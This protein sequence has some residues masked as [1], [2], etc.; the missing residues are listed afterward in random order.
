MRDQTTPSGYDQPQTDPIQ[1][2]GDEPEDRT[3]RPDQAAAPSGAAFT[4]P[5]NGGT[6]DY[7]DDAP[8]RTNA[9]HVDAVPDYADA[10]TP[11]VGMPQ[12][13]H[14]VAPGGD[15]DGDEVDRDD[16]I[17]GPTG[18]QAG[19]DTTADVRTMPGGAERSAGSDE[20]TGAVLFGGDD[21]ERFRGRWREL[22]AD[23]VDDPTQAVQGADELVGEVMRT[24]TEIFNQHKQ[25]LEGQWQGGGSGETEELRVAMRRYR[26]FLD[27]LLNA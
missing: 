12:Q 18:G 24:L 6:V 25:E 4:E 22:Q 14:A 13:G 7:A 20:D 9:N 27:Q 11:P 8:G 21:V 26:S 19:H 15:L 2:L 5:G 16:M 3:P 23:F 17:A 10:A 1:P